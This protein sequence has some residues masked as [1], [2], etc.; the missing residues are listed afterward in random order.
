RRRGGPRVRLLRLRRLQD[1]RAQA[2]AAPQERPAPRRQGPRRQAQGRP[3]RGQGARRERHLRPRPRQRAPQ[4]HEPP[5]LADAAKAFAQKTGVSGS[6]WNKKKIAAERMELFLAVNRGS[7]IEPRLIHLS[8]E[9]KGAK[10]RVVF[11]GKGLTFDSGGLCIKPAQSMND[12][13]CDM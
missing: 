13:K 2:E 5:A 11:V 10:K 12:M 9:P 3:R 8:Y 7:A 1:G 6:V 4:R